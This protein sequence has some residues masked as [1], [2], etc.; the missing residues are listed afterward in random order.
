MYFRVDL[1]LPVYAIAVIVIGI[2]LGY[3]ATI[4]AKDY[5]N[6]N[7]NINRM[8]QNR[9]TYRPTISRR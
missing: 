5:N 8:R 1:I 7:I 3:S 9:G 2:A 4:D 6:I